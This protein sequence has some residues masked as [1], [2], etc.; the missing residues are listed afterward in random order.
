M[1]YLAISAHPDDIDFGCAGTLSKLTS[2]GHEVQELVITDGSKG[3]KPGLAT[4]KLIQVRKEE[5]RAAAE[6]LGIDT[7]HFLDQPDGEVKNTDALRK[8]IVRVVRRFRPDVVFSFDPSNRIFES[9]FVAHRD[10]RKVGEAVFDAL[11]PAA[12]NPAYF[13]GLLDDDDLEPHLVG[14]MWFYGTHKPDKFVDI[15]S[16]IEDKIDALCCHESQGLEREKIREMVHERSREAAIQSGSEFMEAFRV[17]D[18]ER[19]S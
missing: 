12:K 2:E 3:N 14:E 5:Q 18:M 17:L 10:H 9:R 13:P 6:Q 8:E 11:S 1:K 15:E 19:R 7:V 4:E 16:T